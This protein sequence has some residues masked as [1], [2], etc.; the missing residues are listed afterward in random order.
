MYYKEQLNFKTCVLINFMK[1]IKY[2][3]N[4]HVMFQTTYVHLVYNYLHKIQ[5]LLIVSVR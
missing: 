2:A 1:A 5:N 3:H 4:V